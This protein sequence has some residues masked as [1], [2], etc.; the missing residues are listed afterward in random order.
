[1]KKKKQLLQKDI[2]TGKVKS[3][4][5]KVS[6]PSEK[7]ADDGWESLMKIRVELGKDLESE[8]SSVEILS[9]MR[10]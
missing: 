10:R 6:A 1:M 5:S 9:E 2:D 8:K 4:R 7:T 3:K